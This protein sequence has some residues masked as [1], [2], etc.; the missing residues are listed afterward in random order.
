MSE[1]N[2]RFSTNII[3]FFDS[4]DGTFLSPH[5]VDALFG[6]L[7]ALLAEAQASSGRAKTARTNTSS[8]PVPGMSTAAGHGIAEVT[9]RS[10]RKPVSLV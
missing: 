4:V 10:W 1:K 9:L 5:Q 2:I 6:T 3:T 7:I 8:E